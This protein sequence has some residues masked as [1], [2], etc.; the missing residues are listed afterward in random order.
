VIF[1]ER[2][3]ARRRDALVEHSAALRLRIGAASQPLMMKAQAGARLVSAVRATAPWLTR[4]VM[5][6]SLLKRGK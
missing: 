1:G 6:Y 5:I 3:L 4:A 2:E